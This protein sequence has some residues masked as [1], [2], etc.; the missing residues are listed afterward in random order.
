MGCEEQKNDTL[1]GKTLDE[2]VQICADLGLPK[3]TAK[4][5]VGWLYKHHTDDPMA[6]TNLSKGAREALNQR[7]TTSLSKPC[8]ES[9]SKDGTKKY[10]FRTSQGGFIESAYIPD[11]E[12]ATLC[13][14]SQ[15]GC[16]MGCKF[17][18]TARQGLQH[19]LST[20]DILNQI[21]SLPERD[22]LTN[23]VF[24]GMGEPLDNSESVF[25]AIDIMTSEWGFALSPSR[26]TLSTVG[27]T[28]KIREL[29]E[30]TRVHIAVSLHN[31]ISEERAEIVPIERAHPIE[32]VIDILKEYDFS[33]QR[34]VSFEYIVMSGKNN[35]PRHIKHLCRL[36]NG[37]KCRMNLIRFHKIEGSPYFSPDDEKMLRFRDTLTQKGIHT[38]IRTSRGEDIEAACGLL[39]IKERV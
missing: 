8:R 23:F 15:M 19:S 37:L 21:V 17:C 25:R 7:F 16:R 14:S 10:L 35:S 27:I 31:P 12:R 11:N 36:L 6:M 38:T 28:P 13:I 30:R 22:K 4:Q 20:A 5:I 3:F 26:I 24:M 2:I 33:H 29:I 9:V 18:A 39:S 32:G 1:Y 34:R